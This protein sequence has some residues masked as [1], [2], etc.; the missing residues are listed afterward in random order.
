MSAEDA[1]SRASSPI[2][3]FGPA[4][5]ASASSSSSAAAVIFLEPSDLDPAPTPTQLPV[6]QRADP[7]CAARLRAVVNIDV[8]ESRAMALLAA[9]NYIMYHQRK[10][11]P[12][13]NPQRG[14]SPARIP[15]E[16]PSEVGSPAVFFLTTLP[17][18]TGHISTGRGGARARAHTWVCW[19]R[20][21]WISFSIQRMVPVSLRPCS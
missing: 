6:A 15:S 11:V 10:S 1:L 4:R 16:I 13:Q 14:E 12:H 3:V 5:P 2:Q 20:A 21:A 18:T 9:V 17:Y 7:V 8:A 19:S